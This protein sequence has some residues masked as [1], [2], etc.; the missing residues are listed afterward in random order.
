M[1]YG[2]IFLQ[3]NT[4]QLMQSDFWQTSYFKDG[5]HDVL[6]YSLLQMPAP[7]QVCLQILIHT[8][9]VLGI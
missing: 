8:T 4:H 6:R 5:G 9:F 2:M 7:R 1:K 3:I